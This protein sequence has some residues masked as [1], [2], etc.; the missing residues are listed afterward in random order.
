MPPP[1][2][3][4]CGDPTVD[5]MTIRQETEPGLGPFFWK[6]EQ[7]KQRVG[8]SVQAGGS[9]LLTEFLKA[10]LPPS[11]ATIEGVS[12]K[13][14]D[15]DE[16]EYTD[17]FEGK[18]LLKDGMTRPVETTGNPKFDNWTFRFGP[19]ILNV[20]ENEAIQAIEAEVNRGAR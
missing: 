10:L 14:A 13:V 19:Q 16:Y 7:S 9:A 1:L 15:I 12:G 3:Q 4:V 6:P 2:I 18:L 8:L 20:P 5:W 17:T 11:S